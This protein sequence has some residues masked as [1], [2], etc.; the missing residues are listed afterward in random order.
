MSDDQR[1]DKIKVQ[2]QEIHSQHQQA[3]AREKEIESLQRQLKDK[4][5]ALAGLAGSPQWMDMHEVRVPGVYFLVYYPGSEDWLTASTARPVLEDAN[6]TL[7]LSDGANVVCPGH[8]KARFYGP[9]P[10]PPSRA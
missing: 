9:I 8:Y 2:S 7:H 10:P 3:I 6:G 5:A 1:D 4:S